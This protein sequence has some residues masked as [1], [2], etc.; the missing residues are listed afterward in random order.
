M[1][2][3][4]RIIIGP[5]KEIQEV[6]NAYNVYEMMDSVD[7]YSI[8]DLKKIH[9]VITYLAVDESGEFRK[10]VCSALTNY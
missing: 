2:W 3:W 8:K 10:Y 9:G 7:A 6:K 5:Q 1:K 4:M